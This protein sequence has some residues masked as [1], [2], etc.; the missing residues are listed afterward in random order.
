MSTRWQLERS[1]TLSKKRNFDIEKFNSLTHEFALV[2]EQLARLEDEL[3]VRKLRWVVLES[4]H[5]FLAFTHR[6]SYT[7]RRTCGENKRFIPWFLEYI[8]YLSHVFYFHG[9]KVQHFLLISIGLQY[10]I[11]FHGLHKGPLL[12]A[13][14]SMEFQDFLFHSRK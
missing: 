14:A 10:V 7:E 6:R 5:I 12:L 4:S 1:Y 13:M 3:Q 2:S 9:K 11:S 8:L